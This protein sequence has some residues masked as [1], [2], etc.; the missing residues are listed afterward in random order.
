MAT[1]STF[2][3]EYM[4]FVEVALLLV[5][6][7]IGLTLFVGLFLTEEWQLPFIIGFLFLGAGEVC[8]G[9]ADLDLADGIIV[10]V[11]GV[12]IALLVDQVS[13]QL[14]QKRKDSLD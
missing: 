1:L 5:F 4:N 3:G 13:T 11:L 7:V 8:Y 14:A 9:L 6:L 12:G 2:F 10:A